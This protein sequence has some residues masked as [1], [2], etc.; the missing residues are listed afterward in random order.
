MARKVASWLKKIL[1][2]DF[3][4][5]QAEFHQMEMF[6]KHFFDPNILAQLQL[7][8]CS[9][10]RVVIAAKSPQAAGY[11]KLNQ[12]KLEAQ[13]HIQLNVAYRVLIKTS[14]KSTNLAAPKKVF[15]AK[16]KR[17]RLA[18]EALQQ[19]ALTIDDDALQ[20]SLQKLA[21]SLNKKN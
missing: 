2:D 13:L 3:A 14:P 20:Q 4:K 19:A 10:K 9:S 11:L 18:S 16:A 21:K 1:P 7:M 15:L 6:L 8:S 12:A 5:K 17:S